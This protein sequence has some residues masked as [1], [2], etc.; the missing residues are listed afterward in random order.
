MGRLSRFLLTALVAIA[1]PATA[2]AQTVEP[3][4][5]GDRTLGSATAPV[6]LTVYLSTTC[7][8]CADWHT[9]DFPAF[10]ARW[11][12]TGKVRVAYRDLPT[13]PQ[14]AAIAGAVMARCAPEEKYDDV[15]DTLF[16]G[17]AQLHATPGPPPQETVIR[18]LAAAGAAGGLTRD[19]MNAC[20][21]SDASFAEIQ[22]RARQSNADGVNSTPSF[23]ID[24][25]RVLDRPDL[26]SRGVDAFEPLI[27]PLL[28]GR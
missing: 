10:K 17:Q 11:V 7:N 4:R 12:D 9:N 18:W 20:F 21:S 14:Q 5:D 1:A 28:D 8:H 2:L 23:F 15:L 22:Q 6:T 19:Q 16:R 26:T 27:Q 24:G 3:V 25:R 13:P